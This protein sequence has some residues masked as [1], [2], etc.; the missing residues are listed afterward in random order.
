[1]RYRPAPNVGMR[2]HPTD[3]LEG[4]P[5]SASGVRDVH[6]IL[7]GAFKQ[8]V[9]WGWVNRNPVADVTPPAVPRSGIVPPR[10]YD[11][12]RLLGAAMAEDPELGLFLVLA[13][14]LGARRSEVCWLRWTHIDLKRGEVLI[15]GRILAAGGELLDVEWTKNR[16]KRRVA[17]G[18]GVTEQLRV[19]HAEQAKGALALGVSLPENAYVFSRQA[20]G[21]APV[22]PD[23]FTHRFTRL[24]AR[25]GVDSRLHDLRHFM[26]AQ[27]VRAGVDVSTVAGRAG[28][29]DGERTTLNVYSHLQQARDH[30]AA[31]LMEGLVKLPQGSQVR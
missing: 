31:E 10:A 19:R 6:A 17:V 28:Q 23:S 9:V 13:V 20:D 24:A 1:V 8:A 3:C 15:A 22:R 30:A 27:L 16:S 4:F 25:L 14:V 5:L 2:E 18:A 12:E 11:A 26:A 21:L 29:R 7:S